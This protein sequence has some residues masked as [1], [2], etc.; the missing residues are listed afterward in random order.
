MLKL[1]LPV[2]ALA[3]ATTGTPA[4]AQSI[5]TIRSTTW[6]MQNLQRQITQNHCGWTRGVER[7]LCQTTRVLDAA[8]TAQMTKQQWDNAAALRRMQ[9]GQ[10]APFGAGGGIPNP[11]YD[12]ATG[13]LYMPG[14]EP[15]HLRPS[16]QPQ[17]RR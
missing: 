1:V 7:M 11:I 4:T 9:V 8:Q 3:L 17:F 14:Q 16:Q 5:D 12:P 2:L 15:A 13:Q 6:Q 10:P